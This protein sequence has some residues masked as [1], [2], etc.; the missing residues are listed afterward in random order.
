MKTFH[1]PQLFVQKWLWLKTSDMQNPINMATLTNGKYEAANFPNGSSVRLND[2][3]VYNPDQF[4]QLLID[5]ALDYD[6]G[7]GLKVLAAFAAWDEEH[8]PK[9]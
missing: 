1:D 9:S 6:A 5:Y 3:K 4:R 8:E 7:Y 2:G